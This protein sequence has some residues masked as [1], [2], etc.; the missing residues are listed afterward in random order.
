MAF[1]MH[2]LE[3]I[4]AILLLLQSRKKLTAQ[5]LADYFETSVR[6]IYR[7][8]RVLEEAGVPVGA[9]AGVG[10]F[11]LEGYSLPPIMFSREEA[12]AL[13]T[14]EKLI[15]QFGDVS[16]NKEFATALQKVRAVLRSAE[17]DFVERLEE[18][19]TVHRYKSAALNSEEF[20][21]QFI[22]SIQQALVK[23]HSMEITYFAQHNE[24]TT[25]RKINGIGLSF[26]AGS[27]H[28]FAW[29]QSRNDVRDFRVDRIKSLR[30]LDEQYDRSKYPKL[31]DLAYAFFHPT[32]LHRI[33]IHVKNDAV[34]H[35]LDNKQYLGLVDEIKHKNHTEMIFY[36]SPLPLFAK[37]MLLWLDHITI[38]EPPELL[39]EVRQLTKRLY[40]HY[41]KPS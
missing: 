19:I 32:A 2:R 27:W 36:Y 39:A 1:F 5:Y 3:R 31:D 11:L 7:D 38:V 35:T 10:Y 16:L 17:K 6:T 14:G 29:C 34:K 41:Q 33:V 20:P 25:T 26:M 9:E 24:R 13:I 18:N 12:A 22:S 30:I 28:L 15:Q 4:T 21:N 8:I 23:Q 37:W 40:S